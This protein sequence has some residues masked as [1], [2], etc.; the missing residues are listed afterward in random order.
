MRGILQ[1]CR[2]NTYEKTFSCTQSICTALTCSSVAHEP[3]L[4]TALGRRLGTVNVNHDCISL[5]VFPVP[6]TKPT[7]FLFLALL[8]LLSVTCPPFPACVSLRLSPWYPEILLLVS[9]SL[10]ASLPPPTQCSAAYIRTSP[11]CSEGGMLS[12]GDSS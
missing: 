7:F 9:P 8:F 12:L 10:A 6:F 1:A 11:S 5:A 2:A 4:C 3:E